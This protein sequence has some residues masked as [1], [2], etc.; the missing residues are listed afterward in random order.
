MK[1]LL[2]VLAVILFPSLLYSASSADG[3]FIRV[4]GIY[5]IA[6]GMSLTIS[7]DSSGILH[8]AFHRPF[9]SESSS[10]DV[11]YSDSLDTPSDRPI[12]FFWDTP[13]ETLWFA[14]A[15]RLTT[16]TPKGEA[17]YDRIPKSLAHAPK[18]FQ[19]EAQ[20]IFP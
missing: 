7:A 2:L 10:A 3:D 11:T 13:T 17:V 9:R 20:R 8:Y 16:I 5:P 15:K 14:T 6:P 12:L 4:P 18:A 1:I 19:D